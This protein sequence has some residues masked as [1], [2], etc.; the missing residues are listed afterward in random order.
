[1]KNRVLTPILIAVGLVSLTAAIYAQAK[2]N[3]DNKNQPFR[4]VQCKSYAEAQFK[5]VQPT[6]VSGTTFQYHYDEKSGFCT[7]EVENKTPGNHF[8]SR[9]STNVLDSS[10]TRLIFRQTVEPVKIVWKP[11]PQR[12]I[13]DEVKPQKNG[14]LLCTPTRPE[15]LPDPFWPFPEFE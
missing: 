11:A 2:S 5:A 6:D 8:V 13:C 7:V 1:M 3:A 12:L 14:R 9:M 10:P 15:N 4:Q